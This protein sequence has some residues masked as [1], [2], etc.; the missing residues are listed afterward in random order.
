MYAIV[1]LLLVAVLSLL[2]TRVAT[3]A[4]TVTGMTRESA[5]F[6]ARSALTG[7]GFT[8]QES[9]A[10]V[11]HPVRRRIVMTLMLVGSAG[12]VTAVAGLL[13]GFLAAARDDEELTRAATLVGGLVLVYMASR[14]NWVDRHLSRL[15][16]RVLH[17][18]TDLD[19]RDYVRLLHLAGEYSVKEMAVHAGDWMA[20]RSLGLLRMKDEGVLVLGV[21]KG[22]EATYLGAPGKDTI[23][24]AGDTVILYGRDAVLAELDSRPAT[25][26]GQG[27]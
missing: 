6:Q 25:D 12:L 17:R 23:I 11:S 27:L 7:A 1:L 4:L 18:Y 5:R 15:I 26:P 19:V 21:V 22:P 14:S 24:D 10:V 3:V 13:S 8:T 20:G 16:A 2:I 9:E